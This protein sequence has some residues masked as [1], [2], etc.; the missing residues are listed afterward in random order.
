M[1]RATKI[2]L[3]C[4]DEQHSAFMSRFI[5]RMGWHTRRLR[6]EKASRGKG[7]AEQF[8]REAFPRELDAY[9]A[10]RRCRTPTT[11]SPSSPRATLSG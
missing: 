6:I 7:S 5:N 3:L 10:S 1:K 8:A 9:T 11:S 4:E 2:V